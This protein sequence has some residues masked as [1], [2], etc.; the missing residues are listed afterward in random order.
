MVSAG[1]RRRS[2]RVKTA[3]SVRVQPLEKED[4]SFSDVTPA[5][6]AARD[7]IAIASKL[8]V[9]YLGM[10]VRV[11]YPYTAAVRANYIGKVVR[12]QRLDDNFQRISIH[13]GSRA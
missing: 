1:E 12:I 3:Q 13:L 7:G 9:Y 11:T 4:G 2:R 8:P 10:K 6:D 5:L